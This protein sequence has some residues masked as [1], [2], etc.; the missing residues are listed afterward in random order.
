MTG[1]KIATDLCFF[2]GTSHIWA[3]LTQTTHSQCI[4]KSV[5]INYIHL[6]FKI[7]CKVICIKQNCKYNPLYE[8]LQA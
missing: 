3:I 8:V 1:L 6:Y 5:V 2:N 4:S 7:S